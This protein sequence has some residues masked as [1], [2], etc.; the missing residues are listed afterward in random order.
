MSAIVLMDGGMGQELIKRATAPATPIWS[1]Q[2]MMDQPE[3]VRDVHLENIRAGARTI[4]V[5]AYSAM[6]QRLETVGK[7]EKFD[8]LQ[9]L[10]CD[11]ARAARD[12]SGEDVTITGCLSPYAWSYRPGLNPSVEEMLPDYRAAASIQGPKV[13]VMLCE[14]MGSAEEG[15]A[16][17][18][19]A[20]ETGKPVW[21]SWTL[22]DDGSGRLR[23]G[24]TLA[25]ANAALTGL[26][27]AARMVNCSR[28]ETVEAALPDLLSLGGP[29][30]AY[31]NGFT[32]IAEYFTA[33]TTV[34]GLDARADLGPAQYAD[35]AM[36]WVEAGL[37][38]VGGCCEISPAHIGE[39]A[40]RLKAAGH[41]VTNRI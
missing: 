38:I 40:D 18:T 27:I 29:V 30:G 36:R 23:S 16:A 14:T 32:G 37:T 21:V 11:I 31:A 10:A 6:K 12:D 13:D 4:T 22:M 19:A 39:L 15:L 35:F 1:A 8:A 28:P 5:N 3:L 33:G 20:A 9:N 34:D 26:P 41:D 25:E 24:E 7:V 2:V 17:A